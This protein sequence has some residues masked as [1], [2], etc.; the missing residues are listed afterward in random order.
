M[1]NRNTQTITLNLDFNV[2][3]AKI[4]EISNL[5]DKNLSKGLK[6]GKGDSYF[7]NISTSVAQAT[8]EAAQLYKTLSKPLGSK[9]EAVKL[10]K[11]LEAVF[12]GLED[13]LLSFQGNISKTLNSV[14]NTE[15]L[16]QIKVLGDEISKMMDDYQQITKLNAQIKNLG[17]KSEITKQINQAKKDLKPLEIKKQ[18]GALSRNEI[19]LQ[20]ELNRVIEEGNK[21]LEEKA[22]LGDKIKATLAPYKAESAGEL[23]GQIDDKILEQNNLTD[24]S[25]SLQD[26][27]TLKQV[28]SDLRVLLTGLIHASK[29]S[30]VAIAQDVDEQTTAFA[31]AEDQARTFKAVLNSLGLSFSLDFVI[32]GLKRVGRYSYEYIKN[33]D[34]ALTEI[35]VVSNKSR[36]EALA[37]TDTFIELSARTGMAIDDIAQ[38]STIFYQQGLNDKAVE[39]MTEWTALF[40]KISNETVEVAADQLTAAINGF[41]FAANEVGNVVDKMSV[42]AAY[43]AADINELATAMS[44]GASAAAQAGLSFDQYNAYLA[45]MIETTREAPEN[46]GTSLKTIMARF[47]QVKSEGSSEDGE[48]DVNAVETALKSVGIQLRDSQNQLRDLGDVLE[49]LGPKWKTLDRNTQAYL[50]TVIAGTRQ[51]SRFISL[52]QNWDR[53]L[54]LVEASENSAG[55]AT[56]MHAKAMDGLDASL[57]KLTNAWQKLISSL[58]DSDIIKFFVDAVTDVVKW[59]GE[60]NSFMKLFTAAMIILNT[61]TLLTNISLLRQKKGYENLNTSLKALRATTTSY[62]GSVKQLSKAHSEESLEIRKKTEELNK[63]TGAYNQAKAAQQNYNSGTTTPGTEDIPGVNNL[64]VYQNKPGSSYALQKPGFKQAGK[65]LK[66]LSSNILTL[67]GSLQTALLAFSLMYSALDGLQDLVIESSEEMREAA[68]EQYDALQ[69]EMGKRLDLID[70]VEQNAKI[71]DELSSKINKSTDEV[72]KLA[73][74]TEA[75]AEAAPGAVV[76]YDSEG[77]AIINTSTARAASA[78]A[79]KELADQAKK[80]IGNL[81]SLGLADIREEAEKKVASETN[82]D[83]TQKVSGGVAAAGAGVAALSA[84]AFGLAATATTAGAANFWNPVGWGLLIVGGIAAIGGAITYAVSAFEEDAAISAE[85]L[86]A[87]KEKAKE[88][89]E[90]YRGEILQNMSYITDA[91]TSSRSINGTNE[92]QRSEMAAYI[93]S[94]WFKKRDQELWDQFSTGKIDAEEYERQF[95][96][97]GQEWQTTLEGIGE[98]TLATAYKNLDKINKRKDWLI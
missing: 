14:G 75:L 34:R 26:Y 83:T 24:S 84:G 22:A 21:K 58:A 88:V 28:L 57:N 33:L 31:R 62:F 11:S 18:S 30:T 97:I 56:R 37:L 70:A 93:G 86:E 80:Q 82:Y 48:T 47:Q 16:K 46:I 63:L 60:G 79:E 87:A 38:A 68:Q 81:G 5:L 94:E 53:A 15:A 92:Q 12:D 29:N 40:A 59:L 71:Y 50:G 1:A 17:N 72:Q 35:S 96:N 6:S 49:E 2:E 23:K 76:G 74:A 73:E 91:Y 89:S 45:T 61:K 36:E 41:G 13:K 25:L 10:G 65:G 85:E 67:V 44:K 69:E 43:S 9:N 51:Q 66:T 27:N 90:K 77:N 8:R 55:A 7:N 52:M 32:Q 54:E 42:L 98:N 95:K 64:Q 3:K 39:Q 20:E 78:L 4:T 19:K